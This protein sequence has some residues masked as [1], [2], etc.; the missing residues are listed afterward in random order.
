M[1]EMV[2]HMLHSLILKAH[3]EIQVMDSLSL[4]I[5][6]ENNLRSE[7]LSWKNNTDPILVVVVV[8][9]RGEMRKT[10]P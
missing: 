2:L 3:I 6:S 4:Y 7:P 8:K 9:H 5:L 10:F 1:A